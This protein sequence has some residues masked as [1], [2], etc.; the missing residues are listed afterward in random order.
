MVVVASELDVVAEA[1]GRLDRGPN[2]QLL[3]WWVES[4]G[5]PSARRRK[6]HLN[7]CHVSEL[8]FANSGKTPPRCHKVV[9]TRAVAP[10]KKELWG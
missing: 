9:S 8:A 5:R 4:E 2:N 1:V 6:R 10:S 7:D 3:P